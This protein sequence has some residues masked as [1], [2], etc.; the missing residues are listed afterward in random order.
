ML[1]ISAAPDE[2]PE[3]QHRR[4]GLLRTKPDAI[5]R[6]RTKRYKLTHEIQHHHVPVIRDRQTKE[7][8][9][10]FAIGPEYGTIKLRQQDFI[11]R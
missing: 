6:R 4:I 3:E 8:A 1:A 9:R 7:K 2:M 5:S 10:T 11:K